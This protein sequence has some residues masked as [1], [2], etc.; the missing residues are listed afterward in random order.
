MGSDSNNNN[1][2]QWIK[3]QI[4][5]YISALA[6]YVMIVIPAFLIVAM[7]L[8]FAI[9]TAADYYDG[10]GDFAEKQATELRVQA[11]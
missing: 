3:E 5:G 6:G 10:R 9:K 2:K 11:V 1:N 8:F 4:A 7:L